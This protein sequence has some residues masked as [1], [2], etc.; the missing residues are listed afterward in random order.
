MTVGEELTSIPP[1]SLWR[2][3]RFA[4]P[5]SAGIKLTPM[6]GISWSLLTP[7]H[8]ISWSLL[9]PIHGIGWSLLTLM[10]G[11]SWSLLTPTHGKRHAKLAQITELADLAS[12]AELR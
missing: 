3:P 1:L 8:G 11:I 12:R 4:T 7:I 6:H 10:H 9:T 2:N 5:A